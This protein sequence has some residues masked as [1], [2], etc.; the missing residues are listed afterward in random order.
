MAENATIQNAYA[1][2]H[3]DRWES[4]DMARRCAAH[5]KPP[6]LP[7]E[8]HSPSQRLPQQFQSL[9]AFGINNLGGLMTTG[10][11]PPMLP[12]V[13]QELAGKIL[14]DPQVDPAWI[15]LFQ[16]HLFLRDLLIQ[17]L[18][19]GANSQE[20]MRGRQTGFRSMKRRSIEQLLVTGDT[21]ERMDDHFR[22]RVFRRDHYV[23]RRDSAGDVLYHIT[24]ERIDPLTLTDEQFEKT[25]I[26]RSDYD[27]KPVRDRMCNMYSRPEWHPY[28]KKWVIEQEINGHIFNTSEETVSPYFSTPYDLVGGENYGRGFGE[29]NLPDLMT[30][31]ILSE[32]SLDWAGIASKMVP[33][34]DEMSYVKE[35]DLARPTG[36]PIR[37]KVRGG[38]V[39]D[40]TFLSVDKLADWRV[41]KDVMDTVSGRLAKSMLIGTESVRDSERTTKFEVQA[42]VVRQLE[43][44]LGGFY[45]PIADFMQLPTFKRA[46]H[47]AESQKLTRP[48]PKGAVEIKVLTGIS[49][50]ARS[51]KISDI[52][53]I[54]AVAQ[55]L[56]PEAIAKLDTQALI[57]VLARY[58]NVYEPSII[59]SNE[60][61]AKEREALAQEQMKMMAA[62]Q[63]ITTAGNVV[64]ANM[65][66]PA[67]I[68]A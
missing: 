52:M 45:A 34:I 62:Q 44:A 20:E 63:A 28:T 10:L 12:W 25:K 23:T 65:T 56:G 64:E 7:P 16:R 53:N 30:L 43:G 18:L 14:Y 6:M 36:E 54:V 59:K 4:L 42:L 21:L 68:A 47:Q 31:D 2:D 35:S 13:K 8:G 66:Q 5:T 32:R 22:I 67:P 46:A 51:S 29:M 39:D 11:F 27:G 55:Q 50:L 9:G 41:V 3:A 33:V 24:D 38:E 49:A 37:A 26:N 17:S 61:V 1:A 48:L 58:Q 19:E 40:I 60:Q 57:D 15:E